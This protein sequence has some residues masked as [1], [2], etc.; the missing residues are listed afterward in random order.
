M[1]TLLKLLHGNLCDLISEIDYCRLISQTAKTRVR[2]WKEAA[3]WVLRRT[4]VCIWFRNL[5]IQCMCS[6]FNCAQFMLYVMQN[7]LG[8]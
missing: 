4:T 6:V 3:L 8:L 5:Q 2:S 7:T 1:I